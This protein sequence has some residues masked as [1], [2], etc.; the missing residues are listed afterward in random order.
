MPW[1]DGLEIVLAVVGIGALV[2]FGIA[3][4]YTYF[5]TGTKNN[6]MDPS[7]SHQLGLIIGVAFLGTLILAVGLII[8]TYQWVDI[9]N[10]AIIGILFGFLALGLSVTGMS[11]A[12]ITH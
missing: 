9:W 10:K 7:L 12:S 3:M 8:I 1:Y 6:T 2:W 4:G 11:V 5:N